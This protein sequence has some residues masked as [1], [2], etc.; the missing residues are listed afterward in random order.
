MKIYIDGRHYEKDDAKVSVYDHG[1][2]Y[3]V[4]VYEGIRAYN[5]RVFHLR[6]HLGRLFNSAKAILLDIPI[7]REKLEAAIVETIRLNGLRE[8]YSKNDSVALIKPNL[9]RD[10]RRGESSTSTHG[11]NR[12]TRSGRLHSSSFSCYPN[13][14]FSLRTQHDCKG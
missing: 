11:A 1:L 7:A 10:P 13:T 4:G 2:L 8:C 3:G 6:E 5:G 12:A 14:Q 9:M